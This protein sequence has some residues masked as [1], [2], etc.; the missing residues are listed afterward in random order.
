MEGS[1]SAREVRAFSECPLK[2]YLLIRGHESGQQ[3][4]ISKIYNLR[5]RR[6]LDNFLVMLIGKGCIVRPY[7][8][9]GMRNGI[10]YLSNAHLTG[11]DATTTDCGL[12]SRVERPSALGPFSY[13][14]FLFLA[15]H[16]ISVE[17][18]LEMG[19]AGHVLAG[20]QGA[21]PKTGHLVDQ[22][23]R[24]RR[25]LI[26][27]A[28]EKAEPILSRLRAW[29]RQCPK[30]PPRFLLTRH[31]SACRFEA[32]C[33][34]KAEED[35]SVGLLSGM[36]AKRLD[37][38]TRKGLFTT[39]QLSFT[40]RPR[41][42]KRKAKTPAANPLHRLELQALAFRTGTTF[43]DGTPKL[44]RTDCELFLDIEGIPDEKWYYL[45]GVILDNKGALAYRSFWADC[46]D[47]ERQLWKNLCEFVMRYPG[48]PIFHYGAYDSRAV[49]AMA[50][51]HN[52]D[53]CEIGDRLVNVN[54]LIYGTIYFPVRSNSLKELARTVGWSWRSPGATGLQSLAWRHQWEESGD[55]EVKRQLI[56]YNEDDCGALKAITDK[57]SFVIENGSRMEEVGYVDLEHCQATARGSE[58]HSELS[59]ILKTAHSDFDSKKIRLKKQDPEQSRN[60]QHRHSYRRVVPKAHREIRVRRKIKCPVHSGQRLKP[61]SRV[62]EQTIIDLVFTKTGIRKRVTRYQGTITCCWRCRRDYSPPAIT[63]LGKGEIFGHRLKAWAVYLRIVLRLPQSAVISL[64][65]AQFRERVSE[66]SLA[67]FVSQFARYHQVTVRSLRRGLLDG[68]SIHVDETRFNISGTYHYV[69]VFTNGRH[70]V[71][72]M[73]ATREATIVHEI[74][75]GY[76]GVL[77]TDFY[78]GFDS[79]RCRQQKCWSHLI[80]DL[81]DDLWKAP[82]N[83]EF[84]L[85]VSK[86]KDLIVPILGDVQRRGLKS[87]FLRKHIK[88]VER[89][90]KDC[91]DDSSYV[92]RDTIR[93]QKRFRRY[94]SSLFTFL[95]RDGIAWNNNA[96]ERA[97]RHLAIQRKISGAFS[98]RGA[99][100]Y[101][102]LLSV[103]QS[104]RFQEKSMLDFLLSGEVDVDA[105]RKREKIRTTQPN[106]RQAM[107]LDFLKAHDGIEGRHVVELCGITGRQ[108]RHLLKR[109]FDAGI[110]GRRGSP[111][112]WTYYLL[113]DD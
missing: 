29:L 48:S 60:A 93:Y 17:D 112:C 72:E 85:F 19:V 37:S 86:V 89:F 87:Y 75:A 7:S 6:N 109:M 30:T 23:G 16:Q 81:N 74:L 58:L 101:L 105:F 90:Y 71:F 53:G 38:F 79:V 110:L 113:G 78:G 108:A 50:S 99:Q 42:R 4:G 26:H 66:T 65:E 98:Q 107:V 12:L 83:T 32:T 28:L 91:I 8:L 95:E 49:H 44:E 59:D 106:S 21:V 39:T 62:A 11:P 92:T 3:H 45:A 97:L 47:D 103:A 76:G 55:P 27:A 57:L 14:P 36:T 111:S 94:R 46:R 84:E 102:S 31:C 35:D 2:A 56:Q 13:E 100:D 41:R 64:M 43:V 63:R 70:V 80:R 73:T 77:V 68:P 10:P 22:S 96:A 34:G 52:T 1:L 54:S 61:T 33:V 82:F 69:W 18:R 88:A 40:Y 25:I 9:E 24:V 67:K 104:C 20:M 51:R 5:K 15:T